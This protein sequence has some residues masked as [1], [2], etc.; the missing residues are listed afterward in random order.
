M[1]LW[2][3]L[4]AFILVASN[5]E[6]QKCIREGNIPLGIVHNVLLFRMCCTLRRIPS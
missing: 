5:G 3:G 2:L 6:F 1:F 4:E